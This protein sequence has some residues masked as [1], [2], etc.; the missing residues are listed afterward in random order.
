MLTK[1][2]NR[3]FWKV[4]RVDD[5]LL[6]DRGE[7][8]DVVPREDADLIGSLCK[9]GMHAPVL[10][11]DFPAELHPSSTPGHFH[12]YLDKE[13]DWAAYAKLMAALAEA[14]IVQ[15]GIHTSTLRRG[16]SFLRLPE[17]PKHLEGPGHPLHHDEPY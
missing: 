5:P 4:R 12:L 13:M 17:K 2:P 16:A 14:G 7:C 15:P 10:D 9:N 11:I 1:K 8:R 6:P 3:L